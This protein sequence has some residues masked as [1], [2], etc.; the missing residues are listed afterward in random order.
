MFPSA[1]I[2]KQKLLERNKLKEK[3]ELAKQRVRYST[4]QEHVYIANVPE[5]CKILGYEN[6]LG[7][8]LFIKFYII[9]KVDTD[10]CVDYL[11]RDK[12]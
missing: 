7:I 9:K 1:Y 11:L 5:I 8:A 2:A 12:E 10:K 3:V 6:S 4:Y